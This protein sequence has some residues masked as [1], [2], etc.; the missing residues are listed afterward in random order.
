MSAKKRLLLALG[1][2]LVDLVIV[3]PPLASFFVAYVII[4]NPRWVKDFLERLD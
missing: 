2:V 3:F 1:I 4:Y